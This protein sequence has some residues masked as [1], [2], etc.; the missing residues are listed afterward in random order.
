MRAMAEVSNE[1]IYE[2]LKSVQERL[3][4]IE[5]GFVEVRTELRAMNGHFVAMQTDIA[6]LYIAHS[7]KDTRLS[8][9]ERRLD[10]VDTSVS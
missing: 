3:G 1:L 2:V 5:T 7:N 6:N 9:I 8:R 4:N 10:L